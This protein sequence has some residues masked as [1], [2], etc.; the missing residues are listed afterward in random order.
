MR[1]IEGGARVLDWQTRKRL[2]SP[3]LPQGAPTSPAL[4]NLCAFNFDV[5]VQALCE[6]FGVRYTRY[7]DDLTFSG[8]GELVRRALAF[9]AR[10]GAIALEEGFHINHRK[11][12]VMRAATRQRVTGILVNRTP[13]LPREHYDRLKATLHNCIRYGPDTQCAAGITEF[14]NHLAGHIAHL[15][16]IHPQRAAR[17]K[18][19]YDRIHWPG[20]GAFS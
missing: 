7:A 20:G 18:G 3:H 14:R 19:M 10:I 2:A 5:R 4:A 12:R 6:K 8:N 16:G 15:A 1:H 9:E 13:N 11:T 17:L